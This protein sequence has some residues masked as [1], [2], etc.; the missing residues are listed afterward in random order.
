[1]GLHGAMHQL[2]RMAVYDEFCRKKHAVLIATDV[3]ARGLDIPAVDWVVQ[4]DCPE[5]VTTYIHRVGRTARYSRSGEAIL[6]LTPSEEPAMLDCLKAKNIPIEKIDVDPNKLQGAN[7]KMEI[8]LSKYNNLKEEAVR[9]FKSYLKHVALMRNK[10]VFDVASIDFDALARS[11]GLV[12]TPRV[13]F[14]EKQLKQKLGSST[15]DS[16]PGGRSAESS[17]NTSLTSK[18]TTL[19]FGADDSDEDDDFLS[20]AKDQSIG[21]LSEDS[22]DTE[23]VKEPQKTQS[24]KK[25]ITK[26][27]AVKKLLKMNIQVNQ[28]VVFD[29]E[30]EEILDPRKQQVSQA[31]REELQEETSGINISK[32][33]QIMSE[34][35]KVDK[36][37]HAC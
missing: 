36:K 2:R 18:L 28:R 23:V 13:R 37:F 5:D 14:I 8:V 15:T 20:T 29:E 21:L 16:A 3:A 33:K 24:K 26:Y 22:Q 34:E 30:G 10:K 35:D 25:P 27:A 6:L 32:L 9:A 31:A 4:L 11:L 17:A 1:M 12:V 7:V 19:N